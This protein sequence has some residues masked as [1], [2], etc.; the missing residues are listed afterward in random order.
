MFHLHNRHMRGTRLDYLVGMAVLVFLCFLVAMLVGPVRT[1]AKE[2]DVV[3][4]NDVRFLMTKVLQ[5]QEID[6]S[7]YD[8]LIA[9]VSSQGSQLAVI[10]RGKCGGSSGP[11]CKEAETSENCLD[12]GGY[13]SSLLLPA[14]PVDPRRNVY[15]TEVTGYY[16]TVREEELV[17]GSCGAANDPITLSKS[18]D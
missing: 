15:S 12:L 3:R 17:V 1:L 10:G 8:R 13:F 16:L 18:L 9:D 7:A 2:R 11:Y 6:P 14:Q 4:T 5:L